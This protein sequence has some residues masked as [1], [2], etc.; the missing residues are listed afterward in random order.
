ME[1][2]LA[3]RDSWQVMQSDPESRVYLEFVGGSAAKFYAAVVEPAEDATWSVAFNFGRIGFPREWDRKVV[4]V[5]EAKARAALAELIAEKQRKGYERRPWPANLLLP[6]GERPHPEPDD[7]EP[8]Q[9]AVRGIYFASAAGR[10]PEEQA[11]L[12][13][14]LA[15][16]PG[17]VIRLMPEG[18]TRGPAP[19]MWVSDAPVSNVTA[20]WQILANSFAETGLW[21]LIL[22]PGQGIDR[23]GEVMMDVPRSVGADPFALLRRWWHQNSGVEDDEFDEEAFAPLGRAFPGLA[24]RSPGD[25]PL[26]INPHVRD[27]AGHIALVSVER[28]AQTLEKIGWM[29]PANYDL[30]PSQQSAILDTWEDRF[31]AYLV[32]LGFDTLILAVGRPPADLDAATKISAEHFAF[33]PDNIFQGA[34]SIGAYAPQLVG[35]HLWYFWWD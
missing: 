16:P 32:G 5:T 28:P 20:L 15:M 1:A 21:P 4:G 9:R 12:I 18:G 7:A 26:T 19:V 22:D 35:Q 25:R 13:A 6:N 31:D 27:L 24:P 34:E 11:P 14:G 10:L 8:S 33:C 2:T 29:G 17:H 23:M 30:E 3:R